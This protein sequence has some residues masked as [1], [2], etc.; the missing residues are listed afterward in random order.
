VIKVLVPDM[1]TADELLPFLREMDEARVYVKGGP[2]V[3]R[4]ERVL[5]IATG[6]VP[7]AVV[8]NGTVS[9]ELALRAMDLPKGSGV[10]VPA[11]TFMASGQAIV[12]ADL[13]PVICDVDLEMWQLTPAIATR[14]LDL[15]DVSCVM[16]VA[17]FGAP[18][19]VG[20]WETFIQETGLP[21]LID[22]AGA[23]L[24]QRESRHLKL[25]ISYSLNAT[26]AIGAGEGGVVVSSD[27]SLIARVADL[28]NFGAG[29]TNARMSEYHAAVGLASLQRTAPD[30]LAW[31]QRLAASYSE[32]LPA[33]ARI[34]GGAQRGRT[35]LPVQL[36]EGRWAEDVAA[37][38]LAAGFETKAWYRPYLD[39]LPQFMPC[40][41]LGPM[42]V[43]QMLRQRLLGLPFHAFLTTDD[44]RQV[45]YALKDA[46]A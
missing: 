27:A 3:R 31:R 19:E 9:L 10:L 26:K 6:G 14:S 29:G 46:L 23:I 17:A 8:A 11:V 16:P 25:H 21:V 37:A 43:T 35:L 28:A 38:L 20:R 32:N 36:P 5:S 42:P 4:L 18:V 12:N 41:K 22:A 34:G 45:C 15:A 2:L 44:V 39:E 13:V 7:C 33:G 24:E 30:G 1:P 40:Q